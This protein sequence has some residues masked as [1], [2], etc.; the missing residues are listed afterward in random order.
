MERRS[1]GTPSYDRVTGDTAVT[2]DGWVELRGQY[3]LAYDVDYL[4]AY[5]ES[6]TGMASFHL[7]DFTLTYLPPLP[8]QTDIPSVK[9]VVGAD[10]AIGAAIGR[11]QTVGAHAEL[12]LKH[13]NSVTPGNALKWDAT[14]PVEGQ[15]RFEESDAEVGFAVDHHLAVR[16]HTLVWHS[17]VPAWVFNDA[18]GNPMTPTP[19]NKALLLRR[20]ESHIRA[21]M[22]RYAG[23]IGTWDVV[24]EV[25]DEYSSDGMRHSPWYTIAGLDFIR[26]AFRVAHEVD[27]AAKLVLN[28][29]NTDLPAKQKVLLDLQ[30]NL[31]GGVA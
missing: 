9:D 18:A 23:K 15:F 31:V 24:N 8:I 10:F 22:G 26:T 25:V 5:V 14:E 28:E 12:L 16:G 20:E 30:L 17:Q 6:T 11:P 1:G 3:T 4:A 27:P 29:Y 21:L 19:E 13:F 7:D 2:A